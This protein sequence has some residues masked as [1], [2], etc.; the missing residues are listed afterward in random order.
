MDNLK[1]DDQIFHSF[2]FSKYSAYITHN[3]IW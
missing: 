3:A 2:F 1:T